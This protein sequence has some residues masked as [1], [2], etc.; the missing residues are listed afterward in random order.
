MKPPRM[1]LRNGAQEVRVVLVDGQPRPVLGTSEPADADA[2]ARAAAH[3]GVPSGPRQAPPGGIVEPL[4][5]R[6]RTVLAHRLPPP[7]QALLANGLPGRDAVPESGV[8]AT[9]PL[10]PP[11]DDE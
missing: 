9:V 5:L 11:A 7:A 8:V 1:P 2:R 3:W 4:P 10:Q 6:T